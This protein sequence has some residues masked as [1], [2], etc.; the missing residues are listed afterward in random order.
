VNVVHIITRLIVGGAQE[1]TLQTVENQHTL[2]GDRVTLITGPSEGPE[3]SLLGRAQQSGFP[4]IV[5][6][7]LVR[8]IR[9]VTDIR[10][11]RRLVRLLREVHPD[12]VHTHSSK[13]G[14]LGRMAAASLGLPV[15]HTI[16]GASF[17]YGQSVLAYRTYVG[18]ERLAARWTDRFISV[19]D[20]M[21]AE[22]IRAGIAPPEKFETIYSGFDVEPFLH[23][24]QAPQ[25]VRQELGIL[26]Q[27]IV[28]GK[29]GRLFHLKGHE[30][31]IQAA[32]AVV[33]RNPRVRFLL[34]GDGILRQDFEERI[35]RE[36][37]KEHFIFTG[38][39]PPERIPALMSAMD[40]VAHTSQW[41]GLAR[42]LPQALLA[43][44]PVISYDVGGAREVVRPGETGYLLPRD[45]I[46]PLSE[47]IL[48]LAADPEKRERF[49]VAGRELCRQRFRHQTMTARIQAAY[50]RVLADRLPGTPPR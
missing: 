16:H 31:L 32:S 20:D 26:P 47:A 46:T 44:K 18:L 10:C 36:R 7:E 1:N 11:F 2:H 43:G 39:V 15:V 24:Q 48:D 29:V 34:V 8:S 25:R 50:E 5:L 3:G 27:D 6:P 21:S 38:L 33:A 9:P 28:V 45:S 12:I 42:V 41:E 30:F 35:A 14:I 40:M 22:Y 4:L 37:L 19:A 13:A 17:H 23:P 49:G